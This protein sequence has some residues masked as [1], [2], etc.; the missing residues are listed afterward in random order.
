VG[1]GHPRRTLF[2]RLFGHILGPTPGTVQH[3]QDPESVPRDAV[4]DDIGRAA[5]N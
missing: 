4:S 5:N 2:F 3:P 1:P